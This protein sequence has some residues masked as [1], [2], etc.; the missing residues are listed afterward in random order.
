MDSF[1]LN[2]IAGAILFALLVFFGSWT[3]SD[4]I[5]TVPKPEKPG[6]LVEVPEK[7]KPEKKDSAADE[8]SLAAALAGGDAARGQKQIRKCTACHSLE[9]GG[10][11]KIGP[12][13][14]GIV[15]RALAAG[16]GFSYSEA[17]KSK[18][19][20][21]GYE[22]L[23]AFLKNPKQFAAGTKMVFAGIKKAEDRANLILYLRSL[24]GNPPPLPA[25]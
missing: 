19:G 3:L 12:N 8:I 23:D 10:P 11:N 13:L 1:E 22:E 7:A 21:W 2:K 6:M 18:G 5:F 17:L 14:Y 15:G 16:S 20:N 24:G 25:P 9:D 4:I